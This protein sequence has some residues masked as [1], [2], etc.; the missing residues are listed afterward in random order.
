MAWYS[1]KEFERNNLRRAVCPIDEGNYEIAPD[2]IKR[3][4]QLGTYL[5]ELKRTFPKK[6]EEVLTM[7]EVKD[8]RAL[9]TP[10]SD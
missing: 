2:A 7:G 1:Q 8:L 4:S 9:L 10:D 3:I 5:T 6:Y